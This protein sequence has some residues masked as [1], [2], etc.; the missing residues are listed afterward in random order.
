LDVAQPRNPAGQQQQR[1]GEQHQLRADEQCQ[2]AHDVHGLRPVVV[3]R[4]ERDGGA[5]QRA[6]ERHRGRDDRA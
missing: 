2:Q 6:G 4:S 1:E 3:K 5:G